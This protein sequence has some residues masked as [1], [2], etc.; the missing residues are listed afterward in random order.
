M[1]Q[2]VFSLTHAACLQMCKRLCR[3]FCP[4]CERHFRTPRKFVEHIKSAEHKQQVRPSPQHFLDGV[5]THFLSRV[6]G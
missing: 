5:T 6:G 3:P 2:Q 4:V 1:V